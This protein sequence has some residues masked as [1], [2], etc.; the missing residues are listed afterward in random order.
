MIK[1]APTARLL[2]GHV[3]DLPRKETGQKAS[4]ARSGTILQSLRT[5]Q[6]KHRRLGW[7]SALFDVWDQAAGSR[8]PVGS[9]KEM[10]YDPMLAL[11][12]Q[13]RCSPVNCCSEQRAQRNKQTI[14]GRARLVGD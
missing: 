3:R 10:I 4:F 6:W 5:H 14:L 11:L 7:L 9:V 2:P 8:C 1:F 12:H 13:S